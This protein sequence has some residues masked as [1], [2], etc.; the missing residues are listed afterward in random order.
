MGTVWV[1]WRKVSDMG[2]LPA[3]EYE[4]QYFE[5]RLPKKAGVK[6][7]LPVPEK[8]GLAKSPEYSPFYRLIRSS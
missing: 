3:Y 8:A 4:T 6:R 7:R 5:S 1:D 2:V